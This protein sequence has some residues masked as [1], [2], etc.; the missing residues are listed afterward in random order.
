MIK[1]KLLK[2]SFISLTLLILLIIGFLL[3]ISHKPFDISF[4]TKYVGK[5]VLNEIL[6]FSNLKSAT[7]HLN[8]FENTIKLNLDDVQEFKLSR[9]LID[10]DILISSAKNINLSIKATKL[11]KKKLDLK[12]INVNDAKIKT[13]M[14]KKNF[15]WHKSTNEI[16]VN[17]LP[18]SLNSIKIENTELVVYLSDKFEKIV[19]SGLDFKILNNLGK[20]NFFKKYTEEFADKGIVF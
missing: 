17:K 19:F 15:N 10:M 3:R 2:Y 18:A 8:I 11:F 9:S 5:D 20:N 1:Q 4:I 7:V 16:S 12:Y 6:P 14:N 13:F